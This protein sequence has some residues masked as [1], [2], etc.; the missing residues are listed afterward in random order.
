MKREIRTKYNVIGY[1]M[2]V[3]PQLVEAYMTGG[4]VGTQLSQEQ[5]E[6]IADLNDAYRTHHQD[7]F[8]RM[9]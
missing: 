7:A 4:K 6:S 2:N 5:K 1:A 8:P 9:N 3:D